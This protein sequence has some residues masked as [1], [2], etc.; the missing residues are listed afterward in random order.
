MKRPEQDVIR[1]IP[2]IQGDSAQRPLGQVE[3]L[4]V[5]FVNK[6][7]E[8]VPGLA[9]RIN[10]SNRQRVAPVYSLGWL[11]FRFRKGSP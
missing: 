2:R 10:L 11:T 6:F 7:V 5:I 8:L 1:V 4:A 9:T 3:R